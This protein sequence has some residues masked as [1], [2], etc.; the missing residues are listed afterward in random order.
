[1]FQAFTSLK[2]QKTNIKLE[3]SKLFSLMVL[4]IGYKP[5]QFFFF[6]LLE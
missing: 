6:L 3:E 5:Q 4:C 2:S 1:M